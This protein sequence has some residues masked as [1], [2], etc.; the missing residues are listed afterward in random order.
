MNEMASGRPPWLCGFLRLKHPQ[1]CILTTAAPSR[2]LSGRPLDQAQSS[3]AAPELSMVADP[4]TEPSCPA[5]A[6]SIA[7]HG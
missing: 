3:S 1:E 2:L 5:E 7:R 4:V 6:T